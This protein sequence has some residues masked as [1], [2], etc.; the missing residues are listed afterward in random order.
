[1][2]KR[3]KDLD[4]NE[5]ENLFILPS[6]LDYCLMNSNE[7]EE[8][9]EVEKSMPFFSPQNSDEKIKVFISREKEL[10]QKYS[11]IENKMKEIEQ[12]Y[13]K[14]IEILEN[15]SKTHEKKISEEKTNFELF[16]NETHSN[17]TKNDEKMSEI[18]K[19]NQRNS[20]NA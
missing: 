20:I 17:Q 16:Q 11:E 3:K 13:D 15:L 6:C 2:K 1:M 12:K 4:D 7:I 14:R 18:D 8:L 10:F 9:F 5:K 19:K